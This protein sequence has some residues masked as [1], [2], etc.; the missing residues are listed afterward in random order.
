MLN[1]KSHKEQKRDEIFVGNT[2]TIIFPDEYEHLFKRNNIKYRFG[3][4][5]FDI[6]GKIIKENVTKPL[7]IKKDSCDTYNRLM[8]KL[9][10][11]TTDVEGILLS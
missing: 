11:F 3:N 2:S 5:A 9:S 1:Y 7:F 8:R 4:V 10:G 6:H